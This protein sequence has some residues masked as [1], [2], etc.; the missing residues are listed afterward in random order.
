MMLGMESYNV[1]WD[2]R[3]WKVESF[4]ESIF[5]YQWCGLG[6]LVTLSESQ[7]LSLLDEGNDSYPTLQLKSSN[8]IMYVQVF[9]Q[10]SWQSKPTRDGQVLE[11][12][13][14]GANIA[15]SKAV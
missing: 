12:T 6:R 11:A 15:M 5:P 13:I 8:G 4:L 7:C 2:F 9:Q 1:A 3:S 14:L 10:T